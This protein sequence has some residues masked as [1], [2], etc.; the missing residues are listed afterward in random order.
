MHAAIEKLHRTYRRRDGAR[1]RW[2]AGLA[3]SLETREGYAGGHASRVS[4][5]SV[6]IG[7]HLGL[8]DDELAEIELGALLH[9]IG[10]LV[11]P[12]AILG[13]PAALD[14]V[15]WHAMRSHAETGERLLDPVGLPGVLAI[16]RSHHER[17]DG[18]GYPDG[19]SAER[20]PL[21]AR[22]VG[23]ADA[24]DA[25]VESRPYRRGRTA[26]AALH[27]IRRHAGTQFDPGCVAALA[28]VVEN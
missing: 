4:E 15:E 16:V 14:E 7:V 6:A 2:L 3:E 17:W 13:K 12:P 28:A 21:G 19:T 23:V 10:K 18:G 24:F 27:E 20:I 1:V 11:V 26:R 9:D 22:I 8:D 25:I 5:L